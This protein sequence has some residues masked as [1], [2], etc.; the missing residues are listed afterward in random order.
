VRVP[1]GMLDIPSR[2]AQE[3]FDLDLSKN[4]HTVIFGSPG[5][6]K[7]TVLQTLVLNL[8]KARTPDQL[9]VNLIDFGN[10]GLL[11]LKR[12]PNV[13]DIVTLEEAEK[14]S[15]ML[16][17]IGRL[18]AARKQLFKDTGVANLEQYIAKTAKGLPTV[19]NVLDGYDSLT[20]NDRRKDQIDDLLLQ[21]LREG[22]GLGVY[23]VMSASR[24]GGVRVNM[25]SNVST[26]LCLYLNDEG[27]L[28]QLMG[29]ER[30]MQVDAP[31]RGQVL[32]DAPTAIQFY[33]PAPGDSSAET[34]TALEQQVTMLDENWTGPRPNQIPMVPRELTPQAFLEFAS[35]G[36]L[37]SAGGVPLGLST[38]TT[39]ARGFIPRAQP[40]FV[41]AARD[42]EQEVL[43]QQTLL[44]QG[45]RVTTEFIVVDFD[46]TFGEALETST[47]PANFS[48]ITSKSD[49]N[50]IVAGI[51][52]YLNLNKRKDKGAHTVLV[53]A[54]L[55]DFIAG[56]G[57][58]PEDFVLAL[59]NTFKAG[60]DFVIFSRHDYLAKSFDPVPKILR[61][62]KFTGLVG[63]RAYDSPLVKSMGTSTEPESGIDEP[64]FV[65]RGGSTF[66]KIKLPQATGGEA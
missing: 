25:L 5:F 49:A 42:D 26:K 57:L 45:A 15:K 64:F 60:L 1:L 3:N 63:A 58:K 12:L 54:N 53:I 46:D 29:R 16:D 50:Q 39:Q 17:G 24:V 59:K 11:P 23:L 30:L 19:V 9:H 36:A 35:V 20:S 62:L 6:G 22:A 13:A 2:Q 28:A 21:V 56:T 55:P 33:Q 8:A 34:L 51:V 47:L 7:S 41:F 10:N 32:T 14:L 48:Y 37:E 18:L 43:F 40:Y 44:G 61:E 65:L 52:A 31:G 4:G 66:E 38:A 27:E